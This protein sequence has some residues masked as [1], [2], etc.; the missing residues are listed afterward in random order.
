MFL[1]AMLPFMLNYLRKAGV[2]LRDYGYKLLIKQIDC[3]KGAVFFAKGT[4]H[5][6]IVTVSNVKCLT[7]GV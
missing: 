6:N 2:F 1:C 5:L 4:V 7:G 3:N